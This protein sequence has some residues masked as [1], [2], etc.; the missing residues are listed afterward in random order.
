[1][2][3]GGVGEGGAFVERTRLA[4]SPTGALHLGN[5][6]T[7]VINWALARRRGWRV[8]MR[9]EDLDT[10]RTKA[11]A[12]AGA[13]GL[14]EWLGLDWDEGPVYQSSE[15]GRAGGGAYGEAM[16]VLASLGVVYPCSLTRREIEAAASAPHR[17]EGIGVLSAGGAG[18]GESRYPSSLRMTEAD[19]PRVFAGREGENWRFVVRG[20]GV[21]LEDGFRG[22]VWLDPSASVGDF[23]V[24]TKRGEPSYQLAVTVD[25]A[26]QGVTRVVRGDDLLDSAGRQLLL[27]GALGLRAPGWFCHVPLVVGEDG[28]RLAKR[29][30]DTRLARYK[31]E[32][33]RPERVLGLVAHL[34]G[35]GGV[36]GEL[37]ASEFAAGFELSRLPSGAVVFGEEHEA[38]LG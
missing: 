36:R 26:R 15:L 38:W 16:G 4:P 20:G 6:R 3:D 30:G 28:R 21:E 35:V 14:L 1:V 23:V 12:A 13:L 10:P 19:R 11:G 31:A 5:V 34:S 7:F 17:S 32:G 33:V 37:S 9:V 29:H 2:G 27:Y 22:R 18:E 8:L 24:W 25:D